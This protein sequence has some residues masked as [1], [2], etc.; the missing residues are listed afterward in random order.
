LFWHLWRLLRRERPS[1]VHGFTIKCAVYGALAAR[2][3]GVRVRVGAVAGMGYVFTSDDLMARLLRPL[4]SSLLRAALGGHK[5]RLILQNSDDVALFE[6][7]GLVEK[8][9]IRLIRGSGVDCTR[10]TARSLDR[11][12]SRPLRVLL[13]SRLL[14]D[15][16]LTEFVEAARSLR[17]EHRAVEFLLAGDPD[18]GNPASVPEAT[19]R[20][21]QAEG[22]LQWLGHVDDMPGLLA[23]VDLMVA[24]SYREGLPKSLIEAAACALPLITTDVPGCR[25]V[26]T[27]AVDGLLVPVRD[28]SALA[29]AIRRLDEDRELARRLGVAA[30][31]K[32]LREFDERIVIEQTINVYRE[33]LPAARTESAACPPADRAVR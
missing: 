19:V 11:D 3:A 2:L 8:S 6:R 14:W 7:A 30:R 10:F 17:C 18:P 4:V 26:V 20:G 28:A 32:A 5:A 1:L 22:V 33:L 12:P 24:P 9:H 16:G 25:E 31:A 23:S 29:A 27:D 13:A 15:K 21:W